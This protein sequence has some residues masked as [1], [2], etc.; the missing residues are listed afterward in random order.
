MRGFASDN[1][2]PAHPAVLEAM[3]RA[4]TGQAAAYGYDEHTE[5]A[6]ALIR[7]EFGEDTE[8]RFVFNGTAANVLCLQT[9]VR[10][11]QAV[12]CATSSHVNMDECGAPERF[13]GSKLLDVPA[14]DGRLTPALVDVHARSFGDEHR[15]QPAAVTIAQTTEM[16]TVYSPEALRELADHVHGLGMRLH[17]DGSRLAYAAEAL[18]CSMREASRDAGVDAVSL[19]G[20]KIGAVGAEA[21]LLFRPELTPDIAFM[22]KQSMQLA[23]K[24]RY[25]AVQFEALLTDDVWRA[26]ARNGNRMAALLAELVGDVVEITQPVEANAVFAR[27][28]AA[29]VEPLQQRFAFHVW[30]DRTGEVRWMTAWD[31]TEDD[32]R[33]FAAAVTEVVGQTAAR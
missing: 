33:E 20:T 9:M 29:A 30:D 18:G 25:V 31:T 11:H 3:A 4:N 32:V 23:S 24:M 1:Y 13:L 7:E 12:I 28:P 19:G 26:N 21:V 22:R 16:G 15:V 6:T 27:L 5:R 8:V 17:L 10:P 2:A 14:P